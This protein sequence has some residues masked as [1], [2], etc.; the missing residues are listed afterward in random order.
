ML[1]V[2]ECIYADGSRGTAKKKTKKKSSAKLQNS[3]FLHQQTGKVCWIRWKF[4]A[5]G[6]LVRVKWPILWIPALLHSSH[7]IAAS[8]RFKNANYQFPLAEINNLADANFTRCSSDKLDTHIKSMINRKIHK[9]QCCN[10]MPNEDAMELRD[11]TIFCD[12]LEVSNWRKNVK[13]VEF[14]VHSNISFRLLTHSGSSGEREFWRISAAASWVFG[15]KLRVWTDLLTAS[16]VQLESAALGGFLLELVSSLL[17]EHRLA[18]DESCCRWITCNAA[19]YHYS[20]EWGQWTLAF[21]G[22]W[23]RDDDMKVSSSDNTFVHLQC[24]LKI[25]FIKIFSHIE[26]SNKFRSVLL[27]E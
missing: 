20:S 8:F 17:L 15:L 16:I 4:D 27:D 1:V 10:W 5:R 23:T 19:Y 6:R 18:S 2:D 22:E 13:N 7:L 12:L 14:R 11:L 25:F 9:L 3:R 26:F 21:P 24:A